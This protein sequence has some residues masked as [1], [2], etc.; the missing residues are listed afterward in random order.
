MID[1]ILG[2][3]G[4]IDHGKSTLIK[5][6][7]GIDPDRLPE[8]KRRGITIELGF[9]ELTVDDYRFGIVD[10][11]GHEKF[12]R[13]MLA[14]ATGMDL[15]LL[16]VAADDSVKPQTREHLDVLKMLELKAGV[17]ALTKCDVADSDWLELVEEEV[18]ELVSDSF[19]ASAP[20]VRT[21]AQT[22]EGIEELKTS[23]VA[24]AERAAD[25]TVRRINAPFR[26]AIDRCFTLP[27]HGTVAT[28]SVASGKATVGDKLMIEP[29]ATEVRVRT[30]HNHD[31]DVQQI[32]AGQRA[33]VNLAGIHHNEIQRGHEL[34][35]IGHLVPTRLVT[36]Q[37]D[38]LPSAPKPLKRRGNVR[39]HLGTAEVLASVVPLESETI[40]PG[41]RGWVQLFLRE[42]VVCSWQ[43]PFVI[44][45][46]SPMITIGGGR[47]G[48]PVAAKLTKPSP[49]TVAR[50]QDLFA[51]EP[52]QR[53][54]AA[55]YFGPPEPSGIIDLART[56]GVDEDPADHLAALRKDGTLVPLGNA[57]VGKRMWLHAAR[58]D[59]YA[60]RVEAVLEQ[61]HE[62]NPLKSMF[63]RSVLANTF[64]YL[65]DD[66]ILTAV[67]ERM[68][69]AKRI[70]LTARGVGLAS[71]APKL[72]KAERTLL[73]DLI[74]K[75]RDAGFQP[76]TIKEL[77]ADEPKHQKSI[78]PLV[79]L[80]ASDGELV[81][82]GE[83]LLMH[84]EVEQQL[85]DK[86][87]E[88]FRDTD[89]LTISEIRELLGT[90]RKF[91]VP[92]CAYLDRMGVTVRDGDIR[93]LAMS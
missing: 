62:A 80:A 21:S 78:R 25:S 85:R 86:L 75:Y 66:A 4:H 82:F 35:A 10:V 24:A 93:R 73:A 5:R 72:T 44:R 81:E 32:H 87:T 56:A 18:R 70:R 6:L 19:L 39:V 22:G 45:M 88:A 41:E 46:E 76:P 84:A 49:E 74:Q 33:A 54:A 7:T 29:G 55:I 26:M 3:A 50:L 67:L 61:L 68:T 9:A 58:L 47:I 69:K 15:A 64:N 92:M 12:V 36:A 8:E 42:P 40:E 14:G 43:Q 23:L 53:I 52:Q 34:C 1:L 60:G 20:L 59:E 28:G 27:G 65:G 16:V 13:Q 37:V 57:S 79:A 91:A 31:R 30:L 83:N 2:T 77:E 90:T 51:K 11:P 71:R 89:E 17:I 48:V 63:E 38:L